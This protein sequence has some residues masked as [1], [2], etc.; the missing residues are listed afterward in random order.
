MKSVSSFSSIDFQRINHI[1]TDIYPVCKHNRCIDY[2]Y[3]VHI[4][5]TK[6]IWSSV[7]K[8]TWDLDLNLNSAQTYAHGKT[9]VLISIRKFF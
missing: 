2:T 6:P 1:V 5:L 4:K 3:I 9:T 7:L 8:L